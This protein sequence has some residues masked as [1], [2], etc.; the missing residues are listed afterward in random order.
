MFL[1]HYLFF[2]YV[3]ITSLRYLDIL[4]RILDDFNPAQRLKICV[5]TIRRR[6][7]LIKI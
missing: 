3:I 2:I 5:L 7:A 1:K 4:M 6:N